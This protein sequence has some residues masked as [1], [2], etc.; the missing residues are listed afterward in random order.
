MKKIFFLIVL[1]LLAGCQK[2][3]GET[4][5]HADSITVTDSTPADV[6][7]VKTEV[8][9]YKDYVVGDC[10]HIEFSC[11]DFGAAKRDLMDK[12]S[13]ALWTSL[14][15]EDSTGYEIPNPKYIGKQFEIRYGYTTGFECQD[16]SVEPV[17]SKVQNIVSFRMVD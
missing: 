7:E 4:T 3:S 13:Q 5:S 6:G 12:N 8:C 15:V 17:A 10:V 16:P 14:S 2:K 11:G 9:V 1:A